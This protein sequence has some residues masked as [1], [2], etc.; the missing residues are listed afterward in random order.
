MAEAGTLSSLS[1]AGHDH[2]LSL[3]NAM[4]DCVLTVALY[5][6]H[7]AEPLPDPAVAPVAI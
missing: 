1:N 5:R 2:V 6:G 4:A 7:T 3:A